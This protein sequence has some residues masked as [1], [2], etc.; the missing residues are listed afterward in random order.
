M[1]ILATSDLHGFFPEIEPC[2]VLVIAGDN[3]AN[4]HMAEVEEFLERIEKNKDKFGHCIVIAGNHDWAMRDTY[5]MKELFNSEKIHY[6]YNEEIVIDGVKFWGS[7]YTPEFQGWAFMRE[8]YQVNNVDLKEIWS[9]IPED[10]DVLI[11]HGGPYN[12]LDYCSDRHVG[13]M[14][15]LVK[16]IEIKPKVSIFGHIHEGYG[17]MLLNDLTRCYNV[18]YCD[19]SYRPGQK[20]QMIEL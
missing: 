12:I 14:S 18:A 9:H 8:D 10:T 17:E 19:G 15:L 1:K 3:T 7:P 5:I 16:M 4:G 13:S 2:D 6:L 11:T 20:P